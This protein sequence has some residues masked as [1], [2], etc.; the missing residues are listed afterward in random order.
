MLMSLHDHHNTMKECSNTHLKEYNTKISMYSNSQLE[1]IVNMYAFSLKTLLHFCLII[2][3]YN[4][5][6]SRCPEN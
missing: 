4:F 1:D 2:S 6:K 3:E 5:E